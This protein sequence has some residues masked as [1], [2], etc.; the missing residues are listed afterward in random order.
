VQ[1]ENSLPFPS[2]VELLKLALR[3]SDH[4]LAAARTI[5]PMLFIPEWRGDGQKANLLSHKILLR[6]R[7]RL[8]LFREQP[9]GNSAYLGG[10]RRP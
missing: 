2:V 5:P 7:R 3:R 1:A 10:S 9:R 4:D 6:R 8:L